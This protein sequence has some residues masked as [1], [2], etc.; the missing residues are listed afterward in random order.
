M[1]VLSIADL[2]WTPE[3]EQYWWAITEPGWPETEVRP[4]YEAL[5]EMEK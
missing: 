4:A 3:D 2:R 1:T 5:R